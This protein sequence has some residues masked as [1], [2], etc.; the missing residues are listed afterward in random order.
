M[1]RAHWVVNKAGSPPN[2]LGC[3]SIQM[4]GITATSGQIRLKLGLGKRWIP[5]IVR[6]QSTEEILDLLDDA[7]HTLAGISD[8]TISK[9][10]SS[11]DWR[12]REI[13]KDS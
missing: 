2:V 10:R 4:R 3:S 1:I 11:S 8:I 7:N 5:L 12:H 6:C 9:S 13:Q